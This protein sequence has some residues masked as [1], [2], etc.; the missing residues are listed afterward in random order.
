LQLGIGPTLYAPESGVLTLTAPVEMGLS[1]GDYYESSNG[2]KHIFG[3]ASAGLLMNIPLSF[4]PEGAGSWS[5]NL[6]G[7]YYIFNEILETANRGRSTYPVGTASLAVT[8]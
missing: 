1:M 8:F 3:Y 6:G 5:V 2:N 4:V 7:K